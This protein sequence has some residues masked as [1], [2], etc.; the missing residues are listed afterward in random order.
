MAIQG[1][2]PILPARRCVFL[3][4][5]SRKGSF[6]SK[7]GRVGLLLASIRGS[8][9]LLYAQIQ[10]VVKL[11]VEFWICVFSVSS[12]FRAVFQVQEV[13]RKVEEIKVP[14][15]PARRSAFL[16]LRRTRSSFISK[17]GARLLPSREGE[18]EEEPTPL[19]K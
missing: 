2:V 11:F 8:I 3:L 19:Q 9:E 10:I 4:L 1:S 5:W 6:I 15:L 18:E 7:G 14:I 12:R 16:L 13:D 17:G